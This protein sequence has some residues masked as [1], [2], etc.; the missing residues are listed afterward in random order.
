MDSQTTSSPSTVLTY[1]LRPEERA[2]LRTVADQ[3]GVGPSSYAADAVRRAIGTERR[4]PLPPPASNIANAIREATGAIGSLG[5]LCNQIARRANCG[6]PAQASELA[7][8]RLLLEEID[9]RLGR[10]LTA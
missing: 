9:G 1:K 10:A 3:V 7:R 8:I 6:Q 4:R 2:R 5:N